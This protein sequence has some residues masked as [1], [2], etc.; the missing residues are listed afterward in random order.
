MSI[1]NR[2]LRRH[3]ARRFKARARRKLL[4]GIGTAGDLDSRLWAEDPRSVRAQRGLVDQLV[5][6]AR[7]EAM[8]MTPRSCDLCGQNRA[9]GGS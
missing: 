4:E 1:G 7:L 2:A 3:H 8:A 9:D 5:E 6:R